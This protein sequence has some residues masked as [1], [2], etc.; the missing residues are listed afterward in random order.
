MNIG[1]GFVKP[2]PVIGNLSKTHAAARK[3]NHAAD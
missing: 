2:A 1:V 3:T